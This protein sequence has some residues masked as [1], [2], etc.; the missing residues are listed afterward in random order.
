[1]DGVP[2]VVGQFSNFGFPRGYSTSG[3]V[4]MYYLRNDNPSG[5]VRLTF[6]DWNLSPFSR[7]M[8]N[9]DDELICFDFM[10]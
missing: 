9:T 3:D 7:M 1:M 4:Y 6:E 2:T 10:M 5:H 8:V